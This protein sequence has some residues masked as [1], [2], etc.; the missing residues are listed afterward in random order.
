MMMRVLLHLF[1]ELH[2]L[3]RHLLVLDFDLLSLPRILHV[4]SLRF[5][6][7]LFRILIRILIRIQPFR[8]IIIFFRFFTSTFRLWSLRSRG[9]ILNLYNLELDLTL[10]LGIH[11][12]FREFLFY[13]NC[14]LLHDM[15]QL[16]QLIYC[17][18]QSQVP[19]FT[20]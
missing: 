16:F 13:L 19:L 15:L 2:L 17:I 10:N 7:I 4:V 3:V 6:E 14:T 12:L 18:I 20:K 8:I 11:I 5:Q 1:N 9:L